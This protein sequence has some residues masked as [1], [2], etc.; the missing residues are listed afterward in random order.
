[1]KIAFDLDDVLTNTT[2]KLTDYFNHLHGTSHTLVDHVTF[3]LHEVW[4]KP[5]EYCRTVCDDFLSLHIPEL[6]PYEGAQVLLEQLSSNGYE[7]VIISSR[8]S[9]H[10]GATEAWIAKHFSGLK[11][12]LYLAGQKHLNIPGRTKAEICKSI[13]A[14]YIVDDAP[15]HIDDCS[16]EGILCFLWD[17]PWNQDYKETDVA[18]RVKSYDELIRLLKA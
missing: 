9:I 13:G 14:T 7:I 6:S 4:C 15:H 18:R 1:M 3:G 16:S 10:F 17:R 8:P 11:I 12:E 5:E 2:E